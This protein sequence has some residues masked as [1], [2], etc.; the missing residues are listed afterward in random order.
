MLDIR[1]SA[2]GENLKRQDIT[3]KNNSHEIL[4]YKLSKQAM[5]LLCTGRY[6]WNGWNFF[7]RNV[8]LFLIII[9]NNNNNNNSNNNNI[10]ICYCVAVIVVVSHYII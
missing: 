7:R 3:E 2:L 4:F 6:F 10:I 5:Q 1:D 8:Y 9:L